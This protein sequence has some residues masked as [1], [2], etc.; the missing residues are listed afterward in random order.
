MFIVMSI[1]Q[2]WVP[3]GLCIKTRLSAQPL[4]WKWFFI[5]MQINSFS[6]E[7][8]TASSPLG[9]SH[10]RGKCDQEN[11]AKWA[12]LANS[13]SPVLPS[14]DLTDWRGTARSLQERLCTY[15]SLILKVRVFGNSE[16]AY[17][18]EQCLSLQERQVNVIILLPGEIIKSL[19]TRNMA[20][21]RN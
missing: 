14:L 7:R 16:V 6:Q 18:E 17:C 21:W 10:E 9:W 4:I 13:L 12:N 3:P 11:R 20:I 15:C 19:R 2:F 1:T 5:L 8:W